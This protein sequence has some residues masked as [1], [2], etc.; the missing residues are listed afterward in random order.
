MQP[1]RSRG[2]F[3]RGGPLDSTSASMKLAI[4]LVVGSVIAEL[5]PEVRRLMLLLPEQVIAHFALWQPLTYAFIETSALGVIFGAIILWSIGGTLETRWGP[6]RVLVFTLG[7]TVL[8]GFLTAALGLV[9]PAVRASA[10]PGGTVMTSAVWVAY[11][12]SIG[13]GQTGLWGMPVTGNALAWIG[14]GFVVLQGVFS[15]PLSVLP[16]LLVIGFSYVY[17]NVGTPRMLVLKLQQWKIQ[18]DLRSRSKHLRVVSK[19]RNTSA[20]SDRFIH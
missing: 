9:I 2:M 5:S 1:M 17:V 6:R 3:G 19:D 10:F 13:R 15:S 18:R 11:G 20:D 4:A 8:A 12:W 14:V 7:S 16:Q